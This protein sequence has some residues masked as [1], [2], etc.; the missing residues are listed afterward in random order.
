MAGARAAGL[1]LGINSDSTAPLFEAVDVG[2]VADWRDAVTR[3]VTA[4]EQHVLRHGTPLLARGST[5]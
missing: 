3:L 1:V 4:V 2:V 5:R